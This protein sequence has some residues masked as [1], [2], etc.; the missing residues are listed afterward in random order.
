MKFYKT[1]YEGDQGFTINYSKDEKFKIEKIIKSINVIFN[2]ELSEKDMLGIIKYNRRDPNQIQPFKYTIGYG[3][4]GNKE[5][6]FYLNNET[7]DPN[8]YRE[9]FR[10]LEKILLEQYHISV[11]SFQDDDI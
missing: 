10:D 3:K 5:S 8:K 4:R 7:E 6:Y 9:Q 2:L 11:E 1:G